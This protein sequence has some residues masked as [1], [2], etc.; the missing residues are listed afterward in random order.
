MMPTCLMPLLGLEVILPCWQQLQKPEV[1]IMAPAQAVRQHNF[2]TWTQYVKYDK[3]QHLRHEITA[4]T[5][6][7]EDMTTERCHFSSSGLL[8]L[9]LWWFLLHLK[10]A[11]KGVSYSNQKLD[12]MVYLHSHQGNGSVR[13]G[14]HHAISSCAG[15]ARKGPRGG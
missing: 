4:L 10:Q 13:F 6:A 1:C 3:L 11:S 15:L 14:D 8:C 2:V 9:Q 5:L 12:V 7:I